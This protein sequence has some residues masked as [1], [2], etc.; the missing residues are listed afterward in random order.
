VCNT[1]LGIWFGLCCDGAMALLSYILPVADAMKLPVAPV[2]LF[3]VFAK[4]KNSNALA[5]CVNVPVV[6]NVIPLLSLIR[7]KQNKD[8]RSDSKVIS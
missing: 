4:F 5:P 2:I 6:V 8:Y 1:L 3:A 7:Q